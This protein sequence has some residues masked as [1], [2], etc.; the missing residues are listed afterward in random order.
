ML[1]IED[2]I[3]M[4]FKH[5]KKLNISQVFCILMIPQRLE[6]SYVSNNSIS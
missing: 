1:S 3:I 2:N 6:N 5:V 4:H